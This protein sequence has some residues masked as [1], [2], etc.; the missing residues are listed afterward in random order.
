VL[1]ISLRQRLFGQFLSYRLVLVSWRLFLPNDPV[2]LASEMDI[3]ESWNWG[4]SKAWDASHSLSNCLKMPQV[5][6][7]G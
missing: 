7:F 6:L 5:Y 1:L 2:Y 4:Y 3:L